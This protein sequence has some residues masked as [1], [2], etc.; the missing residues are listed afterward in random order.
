MKSLFSRLKH[1]LY[2]I[3]AEA[4]SRLTVDRNPRPL[5]PIP[6]Q[7]CGGIHQEA[8]CPR[9]KEMGFLKE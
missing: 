2:S 6:C 7:L 3:Y 5:P 4:V 8:Y 1:A 9:A